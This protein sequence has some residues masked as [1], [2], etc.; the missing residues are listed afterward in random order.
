[1]PLVWYLRLRKCKQERLNGAKIFHNVIKDS[2]KDTGRS[3]RHPLSEHAGRPVIKGHKWAFNLWFRENPKN[4]LY[5]GETLNPGDFLSSP[6]KM[7]KGYQV[8]M[9][10]ALSVI[11]SY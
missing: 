11:Q 3:E 7:C 1:M 5:G 9:V 4:V 6:N 10:R 8:L 2:G